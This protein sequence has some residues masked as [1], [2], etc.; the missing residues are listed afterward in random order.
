MITTPT[1]LFTYLFSVIWLFRF[2]GV[3]YLCIYTIYGFVSVMNLLTLFCLI[4]E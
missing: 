1:Q 3:I 2:Y 4:N